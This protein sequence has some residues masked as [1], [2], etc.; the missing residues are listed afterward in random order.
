MDCAAV[1]VSAGASPMGPVAAA[2]SLLHASAFTRTAQLGRRLAKLAKF[3]IVGV[4]LLLSGSWI[5]PP[6]PPVSRST[7]LGT[8]PAA[9][10]RPS[11]LP[12]SVVPSRNCALVHTDAT[13]VISLTVT[14]VGG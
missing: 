3:A 5:G 1:S 7:K 11:A 4:W 13:V 6:H 8:L 9:I 14:L 10:L 2:D 12:L